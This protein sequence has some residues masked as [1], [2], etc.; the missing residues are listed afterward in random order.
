MLVHLLNITSPIISYNNIIINHSSSYLRRY[1][2]FEGSYLLA[3]FIS[4]IYM[5]G[6]YDIETLTVYSVRQYN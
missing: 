2:T 5:Y 1:N 6:S 3:G 4:S